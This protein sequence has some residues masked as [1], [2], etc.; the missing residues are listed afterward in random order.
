[1]WAIK[2]IEKATTILLI[3]ILRVRV[4]LVFV[5]EFDKILYDYKDP[6]NQVSQ[7]C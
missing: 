2:M 1:M 7:E 6:W 4:K 3:P 5:T